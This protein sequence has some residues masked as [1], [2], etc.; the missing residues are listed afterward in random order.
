MVKGV[1]EIDAEKMYLIVQYKR[2]ESFRISRRKPY[3][4]LR[5]F[6]FCHYST[7]RKFWTEKKKINKR[8]KNKNLKQ[9]LNKH[10]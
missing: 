9:V 5:L 7:E 6:I 8:G 1:W 4:I 10:F 2:L 3:A